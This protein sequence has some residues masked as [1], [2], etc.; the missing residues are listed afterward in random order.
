MNASSKTQENRIKLN[1]GCGVSSLPGWINIDIV[2]Y[3]NV[4]KVLDVCNHLPYNNVQFIHAEHF[5]EH[6]SI[7][8]AIRFLHECRRVLAPDGILRLST[9]NLDW[10]WFSHYHFGS[11]ETN[12]AAINDCVQLN[13]VFYGWQHK[14]LYNSLF[15]KELLLHCGF[16]K[17]I[18]M[19]YGVSDIPELCNLEIHEKGESAGSLSPLIIFEAG[20]IMDYTSPMLGTAVLEFE[21]DTNLNWH[22]AQYSLLWLVRF[23]KRLLRLNAGH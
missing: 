20:G 12:D 13:R 8:Q 23:I 9:P 3:P 7:S 22:M 21:R 18:S 17:V 2:P 6:L 15:L 5:I 16:S 10:V 4:D 14:Y 19:T 11:W 1:I